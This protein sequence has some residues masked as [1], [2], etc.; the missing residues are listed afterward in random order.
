MININDFMRAAK[1]ARRM[2]DISHE[3]EIGPPPYA[4]KQ[5]ELSTLNNS[6]SANDVG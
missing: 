2:I 6:P 3:V 1:P 4:K 5:Q